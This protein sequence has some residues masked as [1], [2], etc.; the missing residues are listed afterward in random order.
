MVMATTVSR[1]FVRQR[2]SEVVAGLMA[3]EELYRQDLV[4]AEMVETI[5]STVEAHDLLETFAAIADEDIRERCNGIMAWQ[6]W[7]T[8]SND[9][10]SEELDELINVIEGR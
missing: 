8:A 4:A 9:M 6:L 10:T 2:I 7:S 3:E 1:E 5:F